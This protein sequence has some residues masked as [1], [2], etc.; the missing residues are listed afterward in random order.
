MRARIK[1]KSLSCP[2]Y[3]ASSS[4]LESLEECKSPMPVQDGLHSCWQ[5]TCTIF[6][7]HPRSC[8]LLTPP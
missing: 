3:L 1:H 6:A 7:K 8:L 4:S 5:C 2:E